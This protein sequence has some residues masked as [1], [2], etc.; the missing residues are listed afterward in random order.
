MAAGIEL[1]ETSLRMFLEEG[2]DPFRSVFDLHIP[3]SS[4]FL[5]PGGKPNWVARTDHLLQ[6]DAKCLEYT[7]R[8]THFNALAL[9][10]ALV[11]LILFLRVGI[12]V[13][14]SLRGP[15]EEYRDPIFWPG[16]I[17]LS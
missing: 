4:T 8:K 10:E 12:M 2:L 14:P 5:N 9:L 6:N 13:P 1:A 7:Y 11:D 17:F 15:P 16:L 3:D